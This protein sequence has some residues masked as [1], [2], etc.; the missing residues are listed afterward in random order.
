LNTGAGLE[1]IV[2]TRMVSQ[3]VAEHVSAWWCWRRSVISSAPLPRRKKCNPDHPDPVVVPDSPGLY[4]IPPRGAGADYAG[5]GLGA[6]QGAGFFCQVAATRTFLYEINALGEAQGVMQSAIEQ[7]T[8]ELASAQGK[9][10]SLV[11]NG[12]RLSSEQDRSALL[13]HILFGAKEI[14]HCAAA[15]LFLKTER[16]T[17][18][19]AHRTEQD[20]LPSFEIPLFNEDGSANE[21]S[22]SAMSHRI[23]KP[24]SSM[25]F[26]AKPVLICRVPNASVRKADFARFRC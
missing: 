13:K 23:T 25:M 4:R 20:E 16:N 21:R 18:A 11:D 3:A 14:S 9:L 19:F 24:S 22:S 7:R 17:L 10:A 6:S 26:I 8:G 5:S 15:T 1:K 2:L 12:I